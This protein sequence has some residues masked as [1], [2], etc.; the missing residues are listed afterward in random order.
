MIIFIDMYSIE[1]SVQNSFLQYVKNQFTNHS[2]PQITNENKTLH[3][4]V[5]EFLLIYGYNSTSCCAYAGR[6][7]ENVV[8]RSE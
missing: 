4:K 1:M 6:N 7:H 3:F 2:I 8:L 5:L